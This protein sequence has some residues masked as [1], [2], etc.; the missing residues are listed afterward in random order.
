[1]GRLIRSNLIGPYHHVF[2][3]GARR[4]PIFGDDHDRND[5]LAVVADVASPV[6]VHAYVLMGNHY[7]LLLEGD[8]PDLSAMMKALGE[9]YTRRFNAKYGFDGPLFRSRYRSKPIRGVSYLR[10]AVR[11][12][13]R[14]PVEDGLGD[15][16]YRWSSHPAYLGTAPRPSWLSTALLSEFGGLTSYRGMVEGSDAGS[17]GT[18]PEIAAQVRIGSPRAVEFALGIASRHELA[19][20]AAGGRGVRN[21]LRVAAALLA[22]ETTSWSSE[23]LAARYGYSSGGSLRMAVARARARL[24]SDADFAA[25]VASA[26]S[27]LGGA[28]A[29]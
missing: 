24:P 8:I 13:H 10:H 25:L 27:R 12:I 19:V 4:L 15:W 14:N 18:D 7:H 6:V 22:L 5:L 17:G 16:T 20:V 9:R 26:R 23:R 29:A 11:Y 21:D 2:N 3:R 1:M 28:A